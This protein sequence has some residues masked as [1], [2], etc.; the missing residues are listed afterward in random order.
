[1]SENNQRAWGFEIYTQRQST[2]C[3]DQVFSTRQFF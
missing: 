3:M 1:M 2:L